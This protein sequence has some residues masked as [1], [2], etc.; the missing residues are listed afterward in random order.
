MRTHGILLCLLGV[1]LCGCSEERVGPPPPVPTGSL[2]P[3]AVLDASADIVSAKEKALAAAYVDAIMSPGL[4]KLAPLLDEDAH[5]LSPDMDDAHGT[6]GVVHGMDQLFG[7]FDDRKLFETRVWRTPNEQTIEWTMTGTQAREWKGVPPTHK[8]VS[9]QG[10]TLLWTKDDG[11]IV[12]IHVYVDIAVVM[13]QLGAPPSKDFPALSP[14]SVPTGAA[15]VFERSQA[16][17]ADEANNVAIARGALDALENNNESAYLGSFDDAVEVYTQERPQP[18]RGKEDL[19][20][21]FRGMRKSIGQL[22]TTVKNAWGVAQYAIVEYVIDGEQLGPIGWIPA[23][24]DEVIR[25]Q[26]VDVDEIR[27]GKIVKVWRYDNPMQILPGT[28]GG[29][30]STL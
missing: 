1:A 25:F 26:I 18:M 10:L 19:K 8:P 6:T 22:D 24:R 21:Y 27:A 12:D 4:Q 23:Q 13:A 3:V 5:F 29:P 20:T 28:P 2:A 14:A 16:A 11:S 9:F 30:G 17:S 15:Q 7:A